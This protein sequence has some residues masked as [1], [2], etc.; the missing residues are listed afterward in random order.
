M[1]TSLNKPTLNE[2]LT[3][4]TLF[5]RLALEGSAVNVTQQGSAEGWVFQQLS[6]KEQV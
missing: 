6:G 1:P 2:Y 4:F 5:E 3:A